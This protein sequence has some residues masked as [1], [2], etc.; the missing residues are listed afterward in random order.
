MV[1]RHDITLEFVV[2]GRS[3]ELQMSTA[4]A[5]D[6]AMG[7]LS[8]LTMLEATIDPKVLDAVPVG[9]LKTALKRRK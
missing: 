2:A 6:L 5:A 7:L 3:E 4:C 1:A 8:R 9:V